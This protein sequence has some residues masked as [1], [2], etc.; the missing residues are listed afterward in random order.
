MRRHWP[1]RGTGHRQRHIALAIRGG[2]GTPDARRDPQLRNR[3]CERRS[4][5]NDRVLPQH[6]GLGVGVTDADR[7]SPAVF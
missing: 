7:A 1:R 4:S 5:V 3:E 6:N 2:G